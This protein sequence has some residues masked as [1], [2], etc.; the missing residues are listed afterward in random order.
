MAS[1]KIVVVLMKLRKKGTTCSSMSCLDVDAYNL[2]RSN[3]QH[4]AGLAG[5]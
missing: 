4:I 2:G 5:D 3:L 1:T